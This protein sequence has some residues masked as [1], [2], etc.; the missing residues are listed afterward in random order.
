MQCSN[1][2]IY[3]KRS[4]T[5]GRKMRWENAMAGYAWPHLI[6]EGFGIEGLMISLRKL[7]FMIVQPLQ[8]EI[9]TSVRAAPQCRQGLADI[10][11]SISKFK[12]LNLN[13][14]LYLRVPI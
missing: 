10:F 11:I 7:V 2:V 3:V 13:L 5:V 8:V 12:Y 9:C 1:Y 6:V 4:G 14:Y